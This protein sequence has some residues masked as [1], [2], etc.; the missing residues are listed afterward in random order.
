MVF[1]MFDEGQP[2][3]EIVRTLVNRY[4]CDDKTVRRYLTGLSLLK[5]RLEDRPEHQGKKGRFENLGG[6]NHFLW[7]LEQTYRAYQEAREEDPYQALLSGHWPGLRQVAW[8]LTT[9]LHAPLPQLLGFPWQ[10]SPESNGALMV[11]L[12]GEDLKLEL[13][14]ERSQLFHALQEHLPQNQ[15]WGY[16]QQWKSAVGYL[17]QGLHSL[18]RWVK[19]QSEVPGEK[20]ITVEQLRQGSLGLT[21]YFVKSVVLEVAERLC[22][23]PRAQYDFEVT[24][25]RGQDRW[26]LK[27]VRNSSSWAECAASDQREEI[28]ALQRLYGSLME[29]VLESTEVKGVVERWSKVVEVR[30]GLEKELEYIQNLVRFPGVCS[31]Y[32]A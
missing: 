19:E 20:Y 32:K 24:E 31:L 4:R 10:T 7:E 1:R 9:Q 12:R 11:E 15:A 6:T 27:R 18:C 21:D 5:D 13:E 3:R 25:T 23:L 22:G 26:I 29:H 17:T 2:E 28:K 30:K 16:L 14:V 8:D